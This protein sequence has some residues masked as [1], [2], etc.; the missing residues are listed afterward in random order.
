M[1]K[2]GSQLRPD[3]DSGVL[4]DPGKERGDPGVGLGVSGLAAL[5]TKGDDA[6]LLLDSIYDGQRTTAVTLKNIIFLSNLLLH[7]KQNVLEK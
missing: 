7:C 4:V 3:D 5:G 2:Q 6:D 1:V